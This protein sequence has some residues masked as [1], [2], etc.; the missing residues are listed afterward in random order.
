MKT[1]YDA[2]VTY[3]TYVLHLE[4]HYKL[5]D[6]VLSHVYRSEK[7]AR[8]LAS[9]KLHLVITTRFL[10]L[11]NDRVLGIIIHSQHEV[12]RNE[13]PVRNTSHDNKNYHSFNFYK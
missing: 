2:L 8:K 5:Y 10:A 6:S 1:C 4:Y 3:V 11:A 7:Q 12:T 9:R 13:Y